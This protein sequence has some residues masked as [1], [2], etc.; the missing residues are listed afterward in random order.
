MALLNAGV[1]SVLLLAEDDRIGFKTVAEDKDE[2]E[3]CR[4]FL[5]SLQLVSSLF[6]CLCVVCAFLSTVLTEKLF[7]AGK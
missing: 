6:V 7:F 2:H 3:V 5:A 1:T 4:M